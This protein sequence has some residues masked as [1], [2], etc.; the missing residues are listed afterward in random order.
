MCVC[1]H[2]L[3]ATRRNG[4]FTWKPCT[5]S[6]SAQHGSFSEFWHYG[7]KESFLRVMDVKWHLPSPCL[8]A[9]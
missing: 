8:D 3:G 9:S 5:S 2:E 4:V 7:N 6:T 1:V